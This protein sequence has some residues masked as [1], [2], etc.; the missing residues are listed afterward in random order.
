MKKTE[1]KKNLCLTLFALFLSPFLIARDAFS[2]CAVDTLTCEIGSAGASCIGAPQIPQGCYIL[3]DVLTDITGKEVMRIT[4]STYNKIPI[5]GY[6]K[7]GL[8]FYMLKD[9][10]GNITIGKLVIQGR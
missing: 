7:S 5:P 10:T 4:E 6:I 3:S 9:S 2:I 8:Y 1:T